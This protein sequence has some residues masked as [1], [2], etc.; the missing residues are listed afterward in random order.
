MH[1]HSKGILAVPA[2]DHKP[3]YEEDDERKEADASRM[4][5]TFEKSNLFVKMQDEAERIFSG[6]TSSKDPPRQSMHYP[7]SFLK[8]VRLSS[9]ESQKGVKTVQRCSVENQKVAIAVQSLWL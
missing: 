8:Q 7:T 5:K 9:G 6:Y 4:S 1:I 3:N 2:D